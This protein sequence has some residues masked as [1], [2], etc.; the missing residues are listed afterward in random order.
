M[1]VSGAILSWA[2][3]SGESG[4]EVQLSTNNLFS[5]TIFSAAQTANTRSTGALSAN[6][7]YYWRVRAKMTVNSVD[8]YSD[9][10]ERAFTT[11]NVIATLPASPALISPANNALY[12][13]K[14]VTLSWSQVTN[15]SYQYEVSTDSDFIP[16]VSQGSTATGV[17]QVNL[18]SLADN[19]RYYWRVRSVVSGSGSAWSPV[20][21][22]TTGT[23]VIITSASEGR[24]GNSINLTVN[25]N[26][27]GEVTYSVTSNYGGTNGAATVDNN[28]DIL[29]LNSAGQVLLTATVAADANYA[30]G[31]ATQV[32]TIIDKT[33]TSIT[34]NNITKTYSDP[35]FN[36]SVNS[37]STG[38]LTYSVVAGTA[39][40]VTP[41]G[42]VTI[43]DIGTVQLRV[44]QESTVTNTPGSATSTLTV[45][46]GTVTATADNKSRE[47]GSAN[48]AATITY[49]GFKTGEDETVL[50]ATRPA[51]A[52]SGTANATANA[53]TAHAITVSGGT[54]NHYNYAYVPGSLTITKTALAV[55][56]NNLQ[57]PYGAVNPTPT[58]TFGTFKNGETEAVLDT[59][60]TATIA[61]TAT[62]TANA[63]TTHEITIEP[64]SGLDNNYTFTAYESGIL[65]IVKADQ[66]IA[67]N[68]GSSKYLG[69]V[70]FTL[71]GSSNSGLPIS[72]SSSNTD[73]ASVNG[74]I[75]T[76]HNIGTVTFTATQA[77]DNNFNAALAVAQDFEIT[78]ILKALSLSVNELSFSDVLIGRSVTQPV[79]ITN[80]GNTPLTVTNIQHPAQLSIST[81]AFTLNA[82][83]FTIIDAIYTPDVVET[84]AGN[85]VIVSDAT[86]GN[87]I[88]T[89]QGNSMLI[90]GTEAVEEKE[91]TVYPNPVQD[92]L[93]VKCSN[94]IQLTITDMSG[95]VVQT[96]QTDK[97]D[98]VHYVSMKN[99][100]PGVYI[101]TCTA[102]GT[103]I[104]HKILK[105]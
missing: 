18:S 30:Q 22:F 65:T 15:A 99:M 53:G 70:T 89:L 49:S 1:V 10:A 71:N 12:Q 86:R 7:T 77:G 55:S 87:N 13:S 105:K 50:D 48:P 73:I 59:K 100:K 51:A 38:T 83:A 20:Y 42:V 66:Q 62:P 61:A 88:V 28:T 34:F 17:T 60:P 63:G 14:N 92:E 37:N 36:L 54:D 103:T 9:W 56:A 91:V 80:T 52:I 94:L 45:N 21:N 39:A 68:E 69:D 101:I 75:V 16:I 79:T 4:Y 72:Y 58:L 67:F 25:T 3:L 97:N 40:T 23:S 78:N 19:T 96:I 41:A 43:T 76:M 98:S 74:N 95:K 90:T 31:T 93:T 84:W 33:V 46:K 8:Y 44:D 104:H 35:A 6:T 29:I 64:G 102:S 2:D 32:I 85:L 11:G 27:T 57:R 81:T 24:T 26:S 47:Y 82:G 5:P